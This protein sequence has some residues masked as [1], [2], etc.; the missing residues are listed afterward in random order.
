MRCISIHA[1]REGCD[2][3]LRRLF[4]QARNFNPR[5]PRGVRLSAVLKST[6]RGEFQSTHPA[7]GATLRSTS[8]TGTPLH[9]NPR[10][11]R[12]VRHDRDINADGT[13]KFQ[14]THPARGATPT[15]S[16]TFLLTL[17][18]IH[19]PREGCDSSLHGGFSKLLY[20]NPRTPRGVRPPQIPRL[21]DCVPFQSTHPA[22]GA[23]SRI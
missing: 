17:I 11:P 2:R 12:G 18:S 15:L 23:T 9:F 20:F 4:P 10:T 8:V 19:A 5:T 1:P 21:R 14:S 6:G 22:R 7:R 13:V 3:L 16:L